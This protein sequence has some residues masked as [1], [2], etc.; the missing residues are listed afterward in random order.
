[1][2]RFFIKCEVGIT[3]CSPLEMK[4]GRHRYIMA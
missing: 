2:S 3:F 4:D 1:M